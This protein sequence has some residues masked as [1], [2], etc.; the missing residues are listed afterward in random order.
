MEDGNCVITNATT[1]DLIMIGILG[2][3]G[4]LCLII[5]AVWKFII[6]LRRAIKNATQ[7]LQNDPVRKYKHRGFLILCKS[8]EKLIFEA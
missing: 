5:I 7:T 6:P 1:T 2:N 8:A 3:F 4:S